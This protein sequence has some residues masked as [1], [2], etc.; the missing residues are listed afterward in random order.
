VFGVIRPAFRDLNKVP[1]S[2]D[3][4]SPEA[5]ALAKSGGQSGDGESGSEGGLQSA[6]DIAKLTTGN[7]GL[8]KELDNVRALVQ[9][10]PALVAQVVKNW[11]QEDS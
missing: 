1:A 8:E 6:D 7:E 4:N 2:E 5:S 3:P 10:D 9:Q 11:T